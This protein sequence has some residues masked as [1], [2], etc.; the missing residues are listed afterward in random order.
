MGHLVLGERKTFLLKF[1]EMMAVLQ[2]GCR[3]GGQMTEYVV[4]GETQDCLKGEK[5]LDCF[6][7]FCV[8]VY[9]SLFGAFT[10]SVS[11]LNFRLVSSRLGF[12]LIS[13]SGICS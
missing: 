11:C 6:D 4:V 13:S 5:I 9:T 12:A 10:A 8:S 3:G 2:V 7:Y 1:M